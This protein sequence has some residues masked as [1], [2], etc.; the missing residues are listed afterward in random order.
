MWIKKFL[1]RI[2][3]KNY[4]HLHDFII[5]NNYRK[6]KKGINRKLDNPLIDCLVFVRLGAQSLVQVNPKDYSCIFSI[7]DDRKT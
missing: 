6:I 2:L 4:N 1:K 3:E 7:N 5:T